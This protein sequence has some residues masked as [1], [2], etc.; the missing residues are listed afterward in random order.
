M[1]I[2]LNISIVV[3][4]KVEPSSDKCMTR[5]LKHLQDFT[6]KDINLH[7]LSSGKDKNTVI[8][9]TLKRGRKFKNE[10]HLCTDSIFTLCTKNTFTI[11]AK[12]SASIKKI[13]RDAVVTLTIKKSRV[14]KTKCSCPAGASSCCDHIM[15]LLFEIADYSLKGLTEVPQEVSCTSQARK[16]GISGE[17]DSFKEPVISKFV[18]K[19]INKKGANPT[20]YEQK[21]NLTTLALVV[22]LKH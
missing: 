11:K 19:D 14:E 10:G 20:L 3:E 22:N 9:K 16:W 21:I 12:Y 1:N 4:N 2:D 6:L 5:C 13:K 15:A 17:L 18:C 7:R 8:S